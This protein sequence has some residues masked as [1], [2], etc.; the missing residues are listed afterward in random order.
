[1]MYLKKLALVTALVVAS[2]LWLPLLSCRGVLA[3][4]NAAGMAVRT[5]LRN[6]DTGVMLAS[7]L[8]LIVIGLPWAVAVGGMLLLA[9]YEIACFKLMTAL[10]QSEDIG[11]RVGGQPQGP[12]PVREAK[13]FK[14]PQQPPQKDQLLSTPQALQASKACGWNP[15]DLGYT[16]SSQHQCWHNKEEAVAINGDRVGLVQGNTLTQT[17]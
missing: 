13:V 16:W 11:Y 3:A 4:I 10:F 12:Q 5:G 7:L 8:G 2:L 17:A 14:M 1:M 6:K 15:V 9:S